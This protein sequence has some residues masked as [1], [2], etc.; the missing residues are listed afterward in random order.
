MT[1]PHM[2]DVAWQKHTLDWAL[3]PQKLDNLEY[4][5]LDIEENE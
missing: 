3:P 2:R 4:Q 1:P 5:E